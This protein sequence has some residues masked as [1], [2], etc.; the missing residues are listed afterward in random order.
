M[1]KKEIFYPEARFCNFTDIDA[2]ITFYTRVN[3]LLKPDYVVLDVGCGRGRIDEDKIA[4]RRYLRTIRGKV[5]KVIGI[6]VDNAAV[7]NPSIDEFRLIQSEFWPIDDE[8]IDLIVSHSVL[9][10]IKHPA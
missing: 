1:K 9:E 2:M 8:S 4:I 10:H 5:A 3:A 6:D 7:T